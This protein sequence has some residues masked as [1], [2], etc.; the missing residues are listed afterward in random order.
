MAVDSDSDVRLSLS[1]DDA[2]RD[3]SSSPLSRKPDF[4]SF[5]FEVLIRPRS[6]GGEVSDPV[7]CT[8][9]SDSVEVDDTDDDDDGDNANA[10]SDDGN[11]GAAAAAAS[12]R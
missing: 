9:S 12:L 2:D 4:G 3:P 10:T 6:I 5:L 1:S 8:P 11:T 7:G